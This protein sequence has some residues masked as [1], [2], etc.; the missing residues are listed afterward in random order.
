MLNLCCQNA[1]IGQDMLGKSSFRIAM[2]FVPRDILQAMQRFTARESHRVG[3]LYGLRR[4]GKT[5]LLKQWLCSLP[6][7]ERL[8]ACYISVEQESLEDIFADLKTLRQNGYKYVAIDEITVCN[9]FIDFAAPF[10]D[11]FASSGMKIFLAGTDSLALYFAS[12]DALFDRDFILHTTHIPF[13]EWKKIT[14]NEKLDDYIRWGGLLHLEPTNGETENSPP[15]KWTD[16]EIKTFFSSAISRNIQNSLNNYKNI[17]NQRGIEDLIFSGSM[18]SIFYNYFEKNVRQEFISVINDLSN[19]DNDTLTAIIQSSTNHDQHIV[20]PTILQKTFS[21]A[22]LART[23]VNLSTKNKEFSSII[24]EI[25]QKIRAQSEIYL[26]VAGRNKISLPKHIFIQL[27]R[28]LRLLEVFAIRPARS[29]PT[30]TPSPEELEFIQSQNAALPDENI[31]IQPGLRFAQADIV[32]GLMRVALEDYGQL[33]FADKLL[34]ENIYLNTVLGILQ[35]DIVLYE[36]ML[37]CQRV[38]GIH[39]H[40]DWN[41]TMSAKLRAFK[42]YF[43]DKNQQLWDKEIDLVIADLRQGPYF[44]IIEIK[45]SAIQHE[46]QKKFLLD[47]DVIQRLVKNDGLILAKIVL[48]TGSSTKPDQDGVAYKNVVEYLEILN[49][50]GIEAILQWLRDDNG[51]N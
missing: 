45:H 29:F 5:V 21:P 12:C 39:N 15:L 22:D 48:Y 6:E 9:D 46:K 36:T 25:S 38:S 31:V 42:A 41:A 35:E 1:V 3:I 11:N 10:S 20:S 19:I 17:A 28:Y 26:E 51:N 33:S 47:Q 16:D 18:D 23:R 14:K 8:K 34:I 49:Q 40:N 13:A 27:K 43:P 4:T 32:L 44:Y 2:N 24:K 7:E 50:R 30:L 37:A